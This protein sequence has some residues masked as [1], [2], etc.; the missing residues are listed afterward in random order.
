MT[1]THGVMAELVPAIHVF[2]ALTKED[3]DARARTGMTEVEVAEE[4]ECGGSL[5]A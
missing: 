3:V 1:L 4:S 2:V 5:S